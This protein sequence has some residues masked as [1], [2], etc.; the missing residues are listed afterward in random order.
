MGA[1]AALEPDVVL[2]LFVPAVLA[3]EPGAAV[4]VVDIGPA[5]A[6]EVSDVLAL[7]PAAP[8]AVLEVALLVFAA[9]AEFAPTLQ[10]VATT[11]KDKRTERYI[12]PDCC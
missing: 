1:V 7:W 11:T 6:P 5:T 4:S 8:R 9:E 12:F 3:A 2:T 10:A